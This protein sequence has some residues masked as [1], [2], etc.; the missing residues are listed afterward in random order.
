MLPFNNLDAVEELF[1]ARGDEIS[2]VFVEPVVGNAGLIVPADGFL[3]GLRSIT[4]RFG[5]LLVFDEVMTASV[6][7]W[8]EPRSD[9]AFC[10]TLQPSGK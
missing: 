5:A 10:P 9:T 6:L 4:E 3:Q 2:C 1:R 8:V 7:Q